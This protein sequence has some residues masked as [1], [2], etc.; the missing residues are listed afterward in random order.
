MRISCNSV[1]RDESQPPGDSGAVTIAAVP[2][3][4]CK[5]IIGDI[6]VPF[7]LFVRMLA[8]GGM[9][10]QEIR[11]ACP[12]LRK[13]D[14]QTVIAYAQSIPADLDQRFHLLMHDGYWAF[15]RHVKANTGETYWSNYQLRSVREHGGRVAVKRYLA[16]PQGQEGFE[17]VVKLKMI[18]FSIEAMVV[19]APWSNLFVQRQEFCPTAST[20][21]TAL[22]SGWG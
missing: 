7:G 21:V 10:E 12:H 1:Q 20:R 18:P 14:L 6:Y 13:R 4:T 15:G 19:H 5:P 9:P 17:T 2:Y 8:N 11:R 3:E 16:K 22:N